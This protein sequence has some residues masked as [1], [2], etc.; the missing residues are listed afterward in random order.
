M[1]TTRQTSSARAG[2]S[3]TGGPSGV[4]I[5]FRLKLA[6]ELLDAEQTN[7]D[8]IEVSPENY[9]VCG[10]R[11][12]RLLDAARARFPVVSHGLCGDFAGAAA[13]DKPFLD[14]LRAFLVENKAAWYSDHL[15]LT[16][17]AG[18]E[19]HDLVPL[20][21]SKA[22]V[23]RA[24]R[25]VID[26]RDALGVPVAIENVSAYARMPGEEMSEVEF[27]RAVLEEAD[28]LLL[29]DVNNVFVNA[30]NFGFDPDAYIDALPLDRVVEI[31]MAGHR[32]EHD[33][34]RVDT[35]GE[36][37]IDP[38]YALLERT[39]P[40]LA[41]PVPILLER[42]HNI[43]KLSVLEAELAQLKAIAGRVW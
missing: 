12:A 9:L 29:L 8:F 31:H 30:E 39:L 16:T 14:E 3:P 10:G 42:D 38:V 6:E 23:R 11:R 7:A 27:V 37:I 35:H 21:H 13:L 19:I 40:K 2:S 26:V 25:R 28:C 41:G 1:V 33:G 4:G 5:G 43:P 15:C 34:I 24:A 36:P 32:V 18:A 22:A 20:P 17:T